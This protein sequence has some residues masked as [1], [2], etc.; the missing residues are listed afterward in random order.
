MTDMTL[1]D[2]R[3]AA[4]IIRVTGSQRTELL[5]FGASHRR[6]YIGIWP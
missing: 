3:T 1:S 5:A 2:L 6:N 4:A